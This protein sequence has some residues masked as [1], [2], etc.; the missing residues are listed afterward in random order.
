[1]ITTSEIQ[2]AD[3]AFST[4]ET[5]RCQKRLTTNWM[6]YKPYVTGNASGLVPPVVND[7]AIECCRTCESHGQSYVDFDLD[8]K[9]NG[10]FKK[11]GEIFRSAISQNTD[12]HFPV[13]GFKLQDRY[14][15]EYGYIGVV[16]SPGIAYIVNTD[17]GETI[18]KSVLMAI[19]GTWPLIMLCLSFAYLAGI[20]LWV[21][22]S[23]LRK[24]GGTGTFNISLQFTIYNLIIFSQSKPFS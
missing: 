10:A 14:H 18:S 11:D 21:S 6:I 5:C 7:M 16:E 23:V 17:T 4:A 2:N 24:T 12:F 3:C 19:F 9:N 20:L 22:V 1:M 8:G 13:Y 15:H